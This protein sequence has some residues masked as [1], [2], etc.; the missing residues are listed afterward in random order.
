MGQEIGDLI[1]QV[2][3]QLVVVDADV[4]VHAADQKPPRHRLHVARQDMVALLVGVLL[5]RPRRKGMSGGGDR[6]EP[7]LVRRLGHGAAQPRQ[8]G[9]RLAH[10]FA[11]GGGDLDLGFQKLRLDQVFDAG[12]AFLEHGGGWLA[13]DMAGGAVD[14]QV[15]LLDTDG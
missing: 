11:H 6:G 10:V 1:D 15:L 13:S 8:I 7:V 2:D 14:Q 3:A 9:A 5:L 4:H 12:L